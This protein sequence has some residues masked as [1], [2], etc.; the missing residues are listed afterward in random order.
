MAVVVTATESERTQEHVAAALAA[1]GLGE[2]DRLA[3]I[4]GSSAE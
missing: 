4:A 1:H 2:G 3:L